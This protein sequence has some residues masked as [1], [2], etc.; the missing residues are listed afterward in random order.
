MRD[1]LN[2]KTAKCFHLAVFENENRKGESDDSSLLERHEST[3][4]VDG[5]EC[6]AAQLEFDEYVEFRNP[7]AF[8]L[9]I[10]GN[11]ALHH[12]RDV[13]T[14]TTFFLGQ[15]RTVNFSARA[16]A[17][18][19]DATNTGHNK[20]ISELRDAENGGANQP[21]KTNPENFGLKFHKRPRRSFSVQ[22]SMSLKMTSFLA[23][24]ISKW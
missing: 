9:K 10:R 16:D 18:S 8:G 4:F 23:S 5:L 21:V 14:D 6:A 17:G 13:T 15:T 11:R 24:Y 19:S 7:D 2:K 20:K 22:C 1:R 3:I 12:F